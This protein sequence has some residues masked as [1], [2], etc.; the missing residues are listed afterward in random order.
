M[1]FNNKFK[2]YSLNNLSELTDLENKI[3]QISYYDFNKIALQLFNFQYDNN[4]LYKQFTDSLGVQPD[5]VNLITQIPYLPIQFFKTHIVKTTQYETKIIF[6]SSGTSGTKTSKHYI[7]KPGLYKKSFTKA[8]QLF[9]GRETEWC[10]LGLLPSYLERSNS[11]LIVMVDELIKNSNHDFSGFYLDDFEKL[12]HVL[13][14]NEILKQPTL[15]IGV[16]YALL[17]FAEKFKMKL[18]N[19][20]IIET[21]GMKGRREELT[22]EQVHEI[23]QLRLGT[24]IIHSEYGMTELLSQSYS[25]GKGL[26][27]CAP[28]MKVLVRDE[29]D[30]LYIKSATHGSKSSAT[31]AINIIDLA[32]IYSCAFIATDDLGRIYNNDHFEVLGRCDASEV[33][34]CSLLSIDT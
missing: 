19:T 33:R 14:R 7:K 3:F 13:L 26:F 16:T 9:Y 17:D 30:P 22:R 8:F 6:E 2:Y 10:I 15:L 5:Q 32:N 27:K 20:T 11:S 29:D 12:H 4:A 28:W 21:G 24:R 31:G 34:G 18:A 25:A 1:W 23:L